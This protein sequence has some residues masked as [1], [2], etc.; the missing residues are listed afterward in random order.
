VDSDNEN[1]ENKNDA[2]PDRL[3]RRE[4]RAEYGWTKAQLRLGDGEILDIFSEAYEENWSKAKFISRIQETNWYRTNAESARI[5]LKAK[6]DPE[7]ADF[8]ELVKDTTE[9][10]R[11][12]VM[13][14]G[15]PNLSDALMQEV[16]DVYLTQG[17]GAPGQEY[18][19]EQ[20]LFNLDEQGRLEAAD[21]YGGDIDANAQLL[22]QAALANG[23][24]YNDDYFVSAGKSIASGLS[25]SDLW[26]KQ[27]RNDAASK[28]PVFSEQI[29]AGVNVNDIASPYIRS[30]AQTLQL[31][32]ATITLDDPTILGALTNYDDKGRAYATDLGSFQRQLRKDPR[33]METDEAQNQI[34][35]LTARVMQMFGLMAG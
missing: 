6:A 1:R 32:P 4:L 15:Y 11:Q 30:M 19:L 13:E 25:Q 27:I 2:E 23:V 28:F 7:S 10:I 29:Q 33:W 14:L 24:A 20:Y 9:A 26:L 8:K 34:T 22:R 18:E 17:M 35:G 12:R 3:S 31:N 5:Y 21:G 16:V